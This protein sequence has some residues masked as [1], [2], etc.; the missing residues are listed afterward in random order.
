MIKIPLEDIQYIESLKDYVIIYLQ[1]GG[2]SPNRKSA[3]WNKNCRTADFS[4]STGLFW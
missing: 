4:Q 1:D 3:T 2:L